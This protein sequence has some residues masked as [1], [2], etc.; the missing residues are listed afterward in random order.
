MRTSKKQFEIFKKEF[1]K[2]QTKLNCND[3]KV[4]F[5][6]EEIEGAFANIYIDESIKTAT[7]TYNLKLEQC[8]S[9]VDEGPRF[10][11]KHEA[12]HLFLNKLV[13][14]IPTNRKKESLKQWEATVRVL[15]KI[16]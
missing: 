4:Y 8:D 7:S 10:H 6:H 2:W 1:V 12:I 3:Y 9:L 16:L 11:A 5:F 13:Y 15:E 14:L